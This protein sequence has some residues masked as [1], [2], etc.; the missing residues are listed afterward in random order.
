MAEAPARAVA[1]ARPEGAIGAPAPAG[2]LAPAQ[3]TP[4]LQ[5]FL[6]GFDVLPLIRFLR[7]VNKSGRLQLTRDGW[8]GELW[9]DNGSLV[10]ASF[11][12]ERGPAALDAILLALRD[13]GF[14][15]SE[16]LPPPPDARSLELDVDD[17]EAR[18]ARAPH[19][20]DGA[21]AAIP[22][23]AAVPYVL[24]PR[25]AGNGDAE[26]DAHELVLRMSAVHTLLAVNGE[27][28]V[29]ELTDEH[30]TAQ[31]LLDLSV[32]CDLGLIEF[33]MPPAHEQQSV[34]LVR[35]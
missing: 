18:T 4:T 10:A 6:T 27:R 12:R 3:P 26:G 31:V 28:T 11:G 35:R 25:P 21:A 24:R 29:R 8:S 34:G 2:R 5:G 33:Q 9:L 19:A 22:S 1:A 14:T 15:F 17:L 32:L 20:H 16:D 13:A 30:A 7:N 23:P